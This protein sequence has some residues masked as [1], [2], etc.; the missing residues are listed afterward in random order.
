[1]E[2]FVGLLGVLYLKGWLILL[3][4]RLLGRRQPETAADDAPFEDFA[5]RAD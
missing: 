1:M 3:L 2:L 5:D 4:R